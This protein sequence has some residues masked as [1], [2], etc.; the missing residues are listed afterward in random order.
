MLRGYSSI[1]RTQVH[2]DKRDLYL[3]K[4]IFFSFYLISLV[5]SFILVENI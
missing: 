3:E 4:K 1:E 2:C 5:K